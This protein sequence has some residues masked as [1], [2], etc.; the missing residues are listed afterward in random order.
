[1]HVID[2]SYTHCEVSQLAVRLNLGSQETSLNSWLF[3]Q[4]WWCSR[5]KRIQVGG[6]GGGQRVHMRFIST[7]FYSV[8]ISK[9][10]KTVSLILRPYCIY[11]VLSKHVL[12]SRPMQSVWPSIHSILVMRML[13]L[14]LM[15]WLLISL[16]IS[17]LIE[18]TCDLDSSKQ[19]NTFFLCF[20]SLNKD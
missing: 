6:W 10:L 15:Y 12:S 20:I 11:R 8:Q 17:I 9:H 7:S 3:S 16:K 4:C 19:F 18:T 5:T 2:H 1:M 14:L 13:V